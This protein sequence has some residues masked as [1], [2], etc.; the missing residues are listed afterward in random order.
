MPSGK[1]QAYETDILVPFFVRGPGIPK[2]TSSSQIFQNIDLAPTFM[3][4][5]T[6]TT[7]GEVP[8]G[9][10]PPVP[11]EKVPRGFLP[12]ARLQ[13]RKL[14]ST[15]EMDGKSFLP[16]LT[17]NATPEG[18]TYNDHRWAALLELYSGTSKFRHERY[19]DLEG[20]W[21]KQMVRSSTE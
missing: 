14:S 19:E 10:V 3:D 8:E 7:S 2:G 16:I 15:Y 12:G 17:A 21:I 13:R 9:F 6:A 5:A 20:F 1:R 11:D 18:S 4:I